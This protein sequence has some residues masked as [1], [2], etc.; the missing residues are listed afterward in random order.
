MLKTLDIF[1]LE[2]DMPG[3][4]WPSF[5]NL[6]SVKFSQLL[7]ELRSSGFSPQ[8]RVFAHPKPIT[9]ESDI[10]DPISAYKAMGLEL[11]SGDLFAFKDV[12]SARI[13]VLAYDGH[14]FLSGVSRGFQLGTSRGGQVKIRWSKFYPVI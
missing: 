3:H 9:A 4:P 11:Y 12:E 13:G 10:D 2:V 5:P 1:K 6:R 14:G 7:T 8:A